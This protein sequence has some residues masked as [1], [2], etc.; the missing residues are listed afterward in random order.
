M[1]TEIER[2]HAIDK[3]V[4]VTAL[5]AVQLPIAK[6]PEGGYQSGPLNDRLTFATFTKRRSSQSRDLPTAPASTPAVSVRPCADVHPAKAVPLH[7]VVA[8]APRTSR[9]GTDRHTSRNAGRNGPSPTAAPTAAAPTD[10]AS[11]DDGTTSR[12]TTTP[13]GASDSG[14]AKA[15]HT[16]GTASREAAA[17]ASRE[18]AATA[19]REAAATSKTSCGDRVW[20]QCQKHCNDPKTGNDSRFPVAHFHHSLSHFLALS[21]LNE[22]PSSAALPRFTR[23]KAELRVSNANRAGRFRLAP[24]DLICHGGRGSQAALARGLQPGRGHEA[25]NVPCTPRSAE[26]SD[27]AI[28]GNSA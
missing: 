13:G 4:D 3:A 2:L 6:S 15:A 27:A 9:S 1:R 11:N 22:A 7:T 17:T 26:R 14:A 19:S 18:A 8:P 24:L 20:S 23:A 10:R 16:H 28:C 25:S 21:S 5:G 12:P